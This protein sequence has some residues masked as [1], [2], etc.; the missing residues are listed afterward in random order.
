MGMG[1]WTGTGL[2]RGFIQF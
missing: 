2:K 1:Q